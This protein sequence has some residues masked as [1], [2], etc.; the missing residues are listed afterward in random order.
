MS[1]LLIGADDFLRRGGSLPEEISK[2][3]T[4]SNAA[5]FIAHVRKLPVKMGESFLVNRVLR[6]LEHFDLLRNSGEVSGRLATQSE[7]DGNAVGSSYALIKVFVWAIPILGF[8]G[9]VAL[10]KFQ[11]RGDIVD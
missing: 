11:L 3:I 10:A 8:I 1:A 7:I 4:P 5:Q 6:G 9:T 2:D